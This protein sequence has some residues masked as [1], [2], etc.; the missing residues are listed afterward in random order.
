MS[1]EL[2]P[3]AQTASVVTTAENAYL[4]EMEEAEDKTWETVRTWNAI[5]ACVSSGKLQTWIL[6]CGKNGSGYQSS[7]KSKTCKLGTDEHLPR[8][9]VQ[10]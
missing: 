4:E 2:K 3:K 9:Q 1:E 7:I 6:V 5:Q 10:A 8:L